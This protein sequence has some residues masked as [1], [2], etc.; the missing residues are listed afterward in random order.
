[1]IWPLLLLLSSSLRFAWSL[2]QSLPFT[3]LLHLRAPVPLIFFAFT[4]GES[5]GSPEGGTLNWHRP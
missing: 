4:F 5:K 3:I 2:N 1:M